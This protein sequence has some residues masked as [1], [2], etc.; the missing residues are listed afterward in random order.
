MLAVSHKKPDARIENIKRRGKPKNTPAQKFKKGIERLEKRIKRCKIKQP[1]VES[2]R[3]PGLRISQQRAT[4][5]ALM[6]KCA[7]CNQYYIVEWFTSL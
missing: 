4:Y 1:T 5:D 2:K 3:F 7:T 6:I